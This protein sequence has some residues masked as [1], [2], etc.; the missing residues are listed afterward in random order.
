MIFGAQ[1][2]LIQKPDMEPVL[3]IKERI[4]D[5]YQCNLREDK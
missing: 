3:C 5:R 4:Y 1:L 2:W